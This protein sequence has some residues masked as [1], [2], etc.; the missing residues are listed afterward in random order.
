MGALD[1]HLSVYRV[2]AR[3]LQDFVDEMSNSER[4]KE[5]LRRNQ[6]SILGDVL[7]KERVFGALEGYTATWDVNGEEA[8]FG[9]VKCQ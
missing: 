3:V 4:V 1:S 5:V 9:V 2:P 8:S 6:E 7:G